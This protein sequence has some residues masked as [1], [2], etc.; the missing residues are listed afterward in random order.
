[1]YTS[2]YEGVVRCW[3]VCSQQFTQV[4]SFDNFLCYTGLDWQRSAVI[5]CHGDGVVSFA[6]WRQTD[7]QARQYQLHDKKVTHVD[8]HP[9][10]TRSGDP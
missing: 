7:S 8:V 5:G 2:A 4:A 1:M 3:D 9:K 6:D 10:V